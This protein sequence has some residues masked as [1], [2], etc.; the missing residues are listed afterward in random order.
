MNEVKQFWKLLAIVKRKLFIEHFSRYFHAGL[1]LIALVTAVTAAIMRTVPVIYVGQF[2]L[3]I[4]GS[5]MLLTIIA[6]IFKRP[7]QT[8]AAALFDSYAAED[9]VKTA[10][11]YLKDESVFSQL[12]RRDAL[13][14]MKKSLPAI[15]KRKLKLFH[16]KKLLIIIFLFLL[17]GLSMTFP[18][19]VMETAK[20]Q[21]K[22]EEIAKKTKKEIGKLADEDKENK[23]LEELKEETKDM[24]KSKELLE[25]LLEKEAG[26][27]KVKKQASDN[28]KRLKSLTED[29]NDFNELKD[30]LNQADSEKMKQALEQL[31]EKL[32]KLSEQQQKALEQLI[33]DATGKK[34]SNI[35]EMTEEQ[36]EEL[37]TSLEEQLDN[38]IKNAESLNNL[39]I[40]QEQLQKLANSLN[41]NMSNAGLS[42]SNQLSFASQNQSNQNSA[43]QDQNGQPSDGSNRNSSGQGQNGNGQGSGSGSGSGTGSGTG[44]GN[45]GS[46]SGMGSGTGAGFGQGSRELTIP[47]KIDGEESVENDFGQLG[48]G[49]GEQQLAPES[50]V[51]KGTLRSYEEVYGNYERTYRESVDRMDLPAYLED[52]VK[53][54]F[55]D[56]NP[57]G[58]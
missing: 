4:A 13:L 37:M 44:S 43:S 23:Q 7:D 41:Q 46:G 39:A 33:A 29:L 53:G 12:Q 11:T 51:L 24:D 36:I 25:K 14:H 47:E 2:I 49:N 54:Y 19:D 9:R 30:A 3:I 57:K 21:E 22:D 45:G 1:F 5:I 50:P 20:Q 16:W 48:E 18:N 26:L 56:L 55:S 17:A 42:N 35:S 40:S 27:E 52:A 6:G 8:A 10:L 32:P 15:E 58:E 34:V 31:N 38:L 28:E